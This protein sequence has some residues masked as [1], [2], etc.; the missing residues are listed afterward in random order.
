MNAPQIAARRFGMALLLGAAVGL[1]YGF[2]RPL[3]RRHPHIGDLLFAP[4]AITAWLYLSF[5]ICLGDIRMAYTL[6]LFLGAV[7]W[8]STCGRL[9][10]PVFR[11]F[12]RVLHRIFAMVFLPLTK[13]FQKTGKFVK[14]LIASGKKWGIIEWNNRQHFWRKNGGPDHGKSQ[15][16]P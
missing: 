5:G 9:L 12:W 8:E 10:Q 11:L 1:Y 7:L 6:G 2:L 15:Q 13:I 14:F 4:G 3:R 16:S